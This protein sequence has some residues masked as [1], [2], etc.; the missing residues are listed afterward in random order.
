MV[1]QR[2]ESQGTTKEEG[3]GASLG[4]L[5]ESA[6]VG[7]LERLGLL[8]RRKTQV[9]LDSLVFGEERLGLLVG[10]ARADDHGLALPPVGVSGVSEFVAE[11]ERVDDCGNEESC[12]RVDPRDVWTKQRIRAHLGGSRQSAGQWLSDEKAKK[13]VRWLPLRTRTQRK[14]AQAGYETRSQMMP[15]GSRRRPIGR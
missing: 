11:L 12:Q 14:D 8:L 15:L 5:E 10:H 3:K 6:S 13:R 4:R 9:G 2:G 7:L 1:V